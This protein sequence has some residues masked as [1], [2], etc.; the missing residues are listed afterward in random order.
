MRRHFEFF[1]LLACQVKMK[2]TFLAV[3]ALVE[4]VSAIVCTNVTVPV[5]ISARQAL[6]DVPTLRSNLDVNRFVMNFTSIKHNF[7]HEALIGYGT[8]TGRYNI[9]AKFCRPD[10]M[11]ANPT[12]Q[13][14]TH[15]IGFGGPVLGNHE[16]NLLLISVQIRPTGTLAS[17]I[18][19][20]RTSTKR[21]QKAS[22]PSV[23]TASALA[24]RAMAIH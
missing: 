8:V 6:F 16:A 13:Y 15:G 10:N 11:S 24:T 7:T 5:D 17:T 1:S 22:A 19:I 12:V 23:L 18:T 14:L 20:I 4:S 3:P 9:S 21:L 2:L